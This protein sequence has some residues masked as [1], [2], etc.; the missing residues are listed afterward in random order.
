MIAI[1][2]IVTQAFLPRV[3][4]CMEFSRLC[5]FPVHQ[6]PLHHSIALVPLPSLFPLSFVSHFTSCLLLLPHSPEPN[7]LS[8]C[9]KVHPFLDI[10][11]SIYF[12]H[13]C[14]VAL[15]CDC[16]VHIGH[17][18]FISDAH[19]V[20]SLEIVSNP[21]LLWLT[22]IIMEAKKVWDSLS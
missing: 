3:A 16:S 14:S 9:Y 21:F 15:L 11:W 12:I 22:S 8:S 1:S 10:L 18:L 2:V 4:F 5:Y 19:W 13:D 6:S 7:W 17:F 20:C